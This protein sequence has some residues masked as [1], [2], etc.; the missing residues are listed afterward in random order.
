MN[1]IYNE[2]SCS[3]NFINLQSR[4]FTKIT[5][6]FQPLSEAA[7]QRSSYEKLFWKTAANLQVNTHAEV[8]FLK[9]WAERIYDKS[10]VLIRENYLHLW[11]ATSK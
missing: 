6:P 8:Y 11:I 2:N 10:M 3:G 4:N 5:I 9:E 1:Q 7:L